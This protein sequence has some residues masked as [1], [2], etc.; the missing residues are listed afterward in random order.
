MSTTDLGAAMCRA[1]LRDRDTDPLIVVH[2]GVDT[3]RTTAAEL[4]TGQQWTVRLV[5][6]LHSVGVVAQGRVSSATSGLDWLHC[7][8]VTYPADA[9]R[10][11]GPTYQAALHNAIDHAIAVVEASRTAD[12]QAT[13][14]TS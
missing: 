8:F 1:A 5:A 4:A 13:A 6:G 12:Q 14:T 3:W 2:P 7:A 10:I 11:L 9:G